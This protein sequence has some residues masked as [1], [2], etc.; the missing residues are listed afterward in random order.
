MRF[1]IFFSISRTPVDDYLPSEA[2]MF[3]NF[4]SQVEAAD[5]LGFGV[6]WIA[7]SHLSTEVQKRHARPVVP[8][9]KGEI[10]L[11][12]DILQ[13][14]ERVFARTKQI[15]VGSAGRGL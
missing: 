12:A 4:F 10:G 6:A 13:M 5:A 1:D 3:R 9:W 2:E 14:A 11:N 7:E 15:E 8:H